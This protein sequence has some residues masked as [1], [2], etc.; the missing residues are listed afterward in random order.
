ME[1]KEIIYGRNPVLEYLKRVKD[2]AGVELFISKNAHGKIIDSIINE[3][4]KK[5]VPFEHCDKEFLSRYHSSSKHQGVVMLIPRS[6]DINSDNE[7]IGK[8]A[9]KRGILV[10]LDQVTDP[11]NAGAIIR[12]TEALG[13]DGVVVPRAHSAEISGIAAKASA[14]AT[15]HLRVI[16]T[17]NVSNFL[18]A[19]KKAGFWIAGSS[20]EGNDDVKRLREMRPLVIVIGSEG[21]GIRRLTAEKCDFIVRIPLKG[22]VTSLNASVAAGILLY[23]ATGESD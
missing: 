21:R 8:V 11:R 7:F 2:P 13:G 14:G 23:E 20:G 19:V 1:K 3:S 9:E 10:L 12:T 15:A 4:K 5:G 17:G 6:I 22:A 18:D 16:H